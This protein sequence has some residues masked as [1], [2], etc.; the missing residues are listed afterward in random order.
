MASE[1][2]QAPESPEL[3]EGLK[4]L[5]DRFAPQIEQALG[6]ASEVN[7]RV[8][9]FIRENPGTVLLGAATLG[10]LIGRWASRR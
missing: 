8:K 6:Q 2:E 9:S 5:Q 1:T 3:P 10:F 7:E 4:A